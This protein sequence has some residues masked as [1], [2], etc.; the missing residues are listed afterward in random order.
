MPRMPRLAPVVLVL[1]CGLMD[2]ESPKYMSILVINSGRSVTVCDFRS[3]LD[4][5]RYLSDIPYM[6]H[7]SYPRLMT[8]SH[9]K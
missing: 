6:I 2:A 8:S 3:S 1:A 5:V 4:Q 7:W 9:D